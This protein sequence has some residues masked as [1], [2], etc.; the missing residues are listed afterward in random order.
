MDFMLKNLFFASTLLLSTVSVG[1][2]GGTTTYQ[3]LNSF[4]S[5]RQLG[6]SGNIINSRD[7][8]VNL[9]FS[10][11]ASLNLKMSNRGSLSENLRAGGI[12][13]GSLAYARTFGKTVGAAH[14]RYISYGS[15][16]RTDLAGND[17][18]NFSTGDYVLGASASRLINERMSVGATLN[19]IY[20]QLDSYYSFGNSI[21]IGGQYF[22]E[23]KEFVVSGVV[24]NLGIQWKGYTSERAPLP[25][26]VQLGVSKKLSHAPFRFSLTAQH[27]QQWDLSYVDPNAKDK[28]DALTG[29]TIKV[30]KANFFEKAARHALIQTEI[31]IGKKVYFRVGVDIQRRLEMRVANRPGLAGFSFGT[32]FHLKRFSFEY[33]WMI[34]SAAGSQHGITFSMPIG[35]NTSSG[36]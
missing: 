1:Q 21:D 31:N 7:N 19:L 20:S 27:L 9:A 23:E 16:K 33:G 13:A 24:K 5:A 10:N 18:G 4:Y 14:F 17:L 22:N 34:Y 3:V 36:N 2:T 11:P 29:D 12:N 6:M 32:A 15:M 35:K 26:D 8:D 28:I 30:K 25:L